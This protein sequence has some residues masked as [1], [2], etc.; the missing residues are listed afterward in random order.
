MLELWKEA[1]G[2]GKSAGA[3]CMDLSKAFDTLNHETYKFSKNSLNYIQ[4]YLRNRLQ[5]TK[6]NSNFSLW[7]YIFAD[8]PQGSIENH[9]TNRNILNKKILSQQKWFYDYYMVLNR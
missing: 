6:E 3:I 5:R 7:K 8:A 1:L 4:T 2:R 9:D